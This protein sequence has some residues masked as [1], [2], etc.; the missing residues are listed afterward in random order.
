MPVL[1]RATRDEIPN[2]KFCVSKI[3]HTHKHFIDRG[4]F[5]SQLAGPLKEM[6]VD[7]D[8]DVAHFAATALFA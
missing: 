3:I 6:T 2:V 5:E 4:V 7:P 8:R 1:I